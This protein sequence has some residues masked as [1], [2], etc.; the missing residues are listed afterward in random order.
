MLSKTALCILLVCLCSAF[1]VQANTTTSQHEEQ[2]MGWYP[3]H[4]NC[5]NKLGA[6]SNSTKDF[7]MHVRN[8]TTAGFDA[9]QD[10]LRNLTLTQHELHAAVK[11]LLVKAYDHSEV[12]KL[13]ANLK[14]LKDLLKR[15]DQE[16]KRK[17][18]EIENFQQLD[19]NSYSCEKTQQNPTTE[20]GWW[21]YDACTTTHQN[22]IVTQTCS[23]RKSVWY[24]IKPLANIQDI[25]L[26][27]NILMCVCGVMIRLVWGEPASTYWSPRL[28]QRS[29]QSNPKH[30]TPGNKQSKIQPVIMMFLNRLLLNNVFRL[31][32]QTDENVQ[33][34]FD[35]QR[36]VVENLEIAVNEVKVEL[37]GRNVHCPRIQRL[38]VLID[39]LGDHLQH[40]RYF[41]D[42]SLPAYK[43]CCDLRDGFREFFRSTKPRNKQL[44]LC[45]SLRTRLEELQKSLAD[46][47]HIIAAYKPGEIHGMQ[48][49]P[50][51]I[52][53]V[54][55][56]VNGVPYIQEDVEAL[57]KEDAKRK[58]SIQRLM[59]KKTSQVKQAS[60][61]QRGSTATV[62]P[63]A[64][65]L[66][67]AAGANIQGQPTATVSPQVKALNVA[68]GANI[69][70]QPTATVSPQVK[71]LNVAA[72]ANNE[73]DPTDTVWRQ[74]GIQN[75]VAGEVQ[76]RCVG[77]DAAALEGS[78]VEKT[79]KSAT[80]CM[81]LKMA[82]LYCCLFGLMGFLWWTRCNN[83]SSATHPTCMQADESLWKSWNE[84]FW[85]DLWLR[86]A[87]IFFL[88]P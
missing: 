27:C 21:L 62:S 26:V 87:G 29:N 35:N 3:K 58:L 41:I 53:Q 17:N 73:E 74:L 81:V 39:M 22:G 65:A 25:T 42:V 11:D 48:Y 47:Q 37:S 8:L 54:P 6:L 18:E 67:D 49:T 66:D 71:A 82:A 15:K 56:T 28:N 46:H 60:N 10:S 83:N 70:G 13:Q 50:G 61:A 34:L 52:V 23:F 45:A 69:Q 19:S 64:E 88:P 32:G 40:F 51:E 33:M 72:G 68:A 36:F 59:Q 7:F 79:A 77:A 75:V 9:S 80:W 63:Q 24:V 57:M 55:A 16:I 1:E 5:D 86:L 20:E 12:S 85:S 44:A 38:A 4:C 31:M 30:N 84:K 78:A 76:D 14:Q 43:K 2:K